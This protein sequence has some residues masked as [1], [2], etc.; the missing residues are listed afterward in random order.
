MGLEQQRDLGEQH[1]SGPQPEVNF[2]RP[3]ALIPFA[4]PLT[5]CRCTLPSQPAQT[6]S[7][8]NPKPSNFALSQPQTQP[9]NSKVKSRFSLLQ[10]L[11]IQSGLTGSCS[12]K[13]DDPAPARGPHHQGTRV[14]SVFGKAQLVLMGSLLSR[15]ASVQVPP[16]L[17][18][19]S[20]V[21]SPL[22]LRQ[23]SAFSPWF[24]IPPIT[25]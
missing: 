3:H 10:V 13:L 16:L 22:L 12:K 11:V 4:G 15:T 24:Y 25:S 18:R 5:G 20:G 7:C 19:A 21:R 9:V 23:L 2:N 6:S 1:K 8:L 17:L 14:R